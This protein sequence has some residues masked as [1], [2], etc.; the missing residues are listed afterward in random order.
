MSPKCAVAAGFIGVQIITW[1]GKCAVTIR[2][3]L[4][5]VVRV[6]GSIVRV[7]TQDLKKRRRSCKSGMP[8][9]RT[10]AVAPMLRRRMALIRDAVAPI[11][12]RMAL[13]GDVGLVGAG[14]VGLVGAAPPAVEAK[15][16]AEA[17]KR[18]DGDCERVHFF[19]RCASR[20][21]HQTCDKI[22]QDCL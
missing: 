14:D 22:A 16:V 7:N 10:N 4:A 15:Q 2:L 17:A 3:L 11:L 13:M 1:W 20:M 6:E 8:V 18:G 5:K 12:R 21:C 9:L 19:E